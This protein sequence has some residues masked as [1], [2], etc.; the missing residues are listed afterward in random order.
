MQLWALG[1]RREDG[2]GSGTAA[3]VSQWLSS[4]VGVRDH[5]VVF[6]HHSLASVPVPPMTRNS[7]PKESLG[8]ALFR[9]LLCAR[10]Y[11]LPVHLNSVCSESIQQAVLDFSKAGKPPNTKSSCFT[12]MF[13]SFGFLINI[14]N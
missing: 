5:R 1:C 8:N 7:I 12:P 9:K 4:L 11:F 13:Y 14:S 3:W 10:L 6:Q 2:A